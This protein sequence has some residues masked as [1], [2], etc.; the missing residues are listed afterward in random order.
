MGCYIV[1]VCVIGCLCF[2]FVVLVCM[3]IVLFEFLFCRFLACTWARPVGR[4]HI[5]LCRFFP[6]F[7][8]CMFW[9]F[10]GVVLYSFVCGVGCIMGCL[11]VLVLCVL[12]CVLFG[13]YLVVLGFVGVGV[14]V[15]L[16]CIC[17]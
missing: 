13:Y 3:G 4:A 12:R 10:S 14:F 7:F 16:V 6:S 17:V 8:G 15:V 11:V 9:F 1:C 5:I 2:E